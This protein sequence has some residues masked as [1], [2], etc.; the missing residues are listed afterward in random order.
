[1]PP[2][3]AAGVPTAL[4]LAGLVAAGA[5]DIG[6]AVATGAAVV[7][8]QA[9]L[10]RPT[11]RGI[12]AVEA[13][14]RRLIRDP[15]EAAPD[16]GQ[17]GAAAE[18][19]SAIGQL[20]RS[21]IAENDRLRHQIRAIETI[22]DSV[23]DPLLLLDDAGRI[24]RGN[25]A[26]RTLFGRKLA[27]RRDL[28]AVLRD[29]AVL[30]AVDTVLRS[31]EG[32]RDVEFTLTAPVERHMAA[33]VE[34]LPPPSLDG[35]AALLSL[36]DLTAI[37]RMERM[38]AD[39]V[40]NA[41]HELRT[42]L[43]TLLGFIETLQGPARDDPEARERFLGVMHDQA[44]R[45]ARLIEDLL[46]LSR[47]ELHEHTQPTGRVDLPAVL[48]RIAAT[49]EIRA[50][51]RG[52]RIVQ[53]IAP[54]LPPV[55]G[56]EDEL[57]QVFQNLIDNAVKYGRENSAVTITATRLPPGAVT[58][59]DD[60]AAGA[61]AVSVTDEGEGIPPEHLPRLT[62]RFY[63]VDSARSRKLGGTGLGLAIVKHIVNRHRGLL[64]TESVVGR[65][66]VFT[67]RLPVA[68]ETA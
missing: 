42:P 58:A 37:R 11:L 45:M 36:H 1:M 14:L 30:D 19:G 65:G 25:K 38:R 41:S 33:R 63:R 43:S 31:R 9:F 68:P 66:S 29:S 15:N 49:L 23:P 13:Y 16:F 12:A 35:S 52:V 7:V 34:P 10:L 51:E 50:R 59:N 54:D 67:V 8:A 4:G 57:I 2:L 28:A 47:I 55:V 20:N 18:L 24:V 40:A 46:S 62:E 3:A 5:L 60:L 44:T 21:W 53:D 6:P 27:N 22:L 56:D 64:T 48:R 26:A 17:S 39:F 32:G 61:V